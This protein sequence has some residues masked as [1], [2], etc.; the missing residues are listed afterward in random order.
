MN[1]SVVLVPLHRKKGAFT[2]EINSKHIFENTFP[3]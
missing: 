1:L 3:G 2:K